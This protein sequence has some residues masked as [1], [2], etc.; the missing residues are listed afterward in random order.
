MLR[1][2]LRAASCELRELSSELRAQSCEIANIQ[3]IHTV[4]AMRLRG[5]RDCEVINPI[6]AIT[7]PTPAS[8]AL[9]KLVRLRLLF[10]ARLNNDA[11]SIDAV[12][13]VV[14]HTRDE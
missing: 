9:A 7:V 3:K 5:S 10:V 13:V 6:T 4:C 12:R 11:G 2:L 1:V 14:A 8:S